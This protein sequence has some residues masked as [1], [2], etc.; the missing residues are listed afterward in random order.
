MIL[1]LMQKFTL[2]LIA[3]VVRNIILGYELLTWV[4]GKV[5]MLRFTIVI[6]KLNLSGKIENK[7]SCRNV[8]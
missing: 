8:K 2:Y 5:E 1:S 7:L 4:R 6:I 3:H